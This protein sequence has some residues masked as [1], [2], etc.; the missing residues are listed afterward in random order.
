MK[1]IDFSYESISGKYE[2]YWELKKDKFY[3]NVIIPYGCKAEIILPN[4]EKYNIGYGKYHFECKLNKAIYSPFSINTPLL[5]IIKDDKDNKI[6]QKLLPKI[7]S[8]ITENKIYANY[9][10][11]DLNLL[12]NIKYPSNIIKKCDEE[13]SRLNP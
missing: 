13:L 6:I 3:L 9:S 10:I 2:I 1:K 8:L 12:T 4:N 5:D 7:Y 11:T